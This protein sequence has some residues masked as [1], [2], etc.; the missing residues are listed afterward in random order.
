MGARIQAFDPE[1]HEAR[2]LLP[3]VTFMDG[4][5]E[6]AHGADALVILT[7][8]DEFRA[9]DLDRLRDVMRAPQIID[10]RNIYRP[11]EMRDRGFAYA[12]IGRA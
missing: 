1:G 2:A 3:E 11:E 8:W 9:L 10:L 4:P 6:V 12:S 5:Y 7:E